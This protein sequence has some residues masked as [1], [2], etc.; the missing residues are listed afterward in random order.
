MFCFHNAELS[1]CTLAWYIVE[2]NERLLGVLARKD[3]EP[4]IKGNYSSKSDDAKNVVLH[5]K[6]GFRPDIRPQ[7]HTV[8]A[9][10]IWSIA[11][12]PVAYIPKSYQEVLS[13]VGIC[14]W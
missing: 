11:P 9:K 4:S 8:V 12:V 3:F 13:R 2:R 7:L 14:Q 5:D 6:T 10:S 1:S